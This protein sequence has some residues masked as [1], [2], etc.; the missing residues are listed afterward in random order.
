[1]SVR[2]AIGNFSRMTQLS[3]KM[4]RHYHDLGILVPAA[5]DPVSG[6]RYYTVD[7]V[8]VAQVVRRL[9]ELGM[10]LTEIKAVLQAADL[11]SRNDLILAHLARMESQLA[12]L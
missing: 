10:P 3:I 11:S 2:V 7:Q 5:V 9:R 12:G 6:Y 8:P 1:M 4:L